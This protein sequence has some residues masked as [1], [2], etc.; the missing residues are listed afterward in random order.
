MKSSDGFTLIEL[1]ITIVISTILAGI[2][3][4]FFSLGANTYNLISNSQDLI[5][6]R[7]IVFQRMSREIRQAENLTVAN[8]TDINFTFDI[9]GDGLNETVRYF[10]SGSELH[11]TI[12][13][14]GN[15]VVLDSITALSF[16][17]SGSLITLTVTTHK[18][19]ATTTMQT[20]FLR[21]QSLP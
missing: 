9:D 18:Q 8:S 13:G 15:M 11:K 14:T 16:S 10:L 2:L 6:D 4:N 21:R 12:N 17:G 3:A 19:D 5:Q 7:R 20:G 1:I